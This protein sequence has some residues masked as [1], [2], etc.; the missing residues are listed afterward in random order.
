MTSEA[1]YCFDRA[2]VRFAIYPEGPKG[3]RILAEISEDALRDI[4]GACE[5]GE[6]LVQAAQDNFDL[7]EA[8]ALL[9]HRDDPSK[10]IA[11]EIADFACPV[12]G[13]AAAL[14]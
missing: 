6:S 7:I 13:Q 2:V 5:G 4:F 9:R 14:F 12:N 10:P 8:T 3:R 1:I 11:L